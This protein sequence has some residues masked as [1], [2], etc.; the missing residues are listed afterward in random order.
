MEC[1][2][3]EVHV[4]GLEYMIVYVNK[5]SIGYVHHTKCFLP[6]CLQR[7]TRN[8]AIRRA[9]PCVW[10]GERHMPEALSLCHFPLWSSLPLRQVP[11]VPR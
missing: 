3:A 9:E 2:F 8:E 1:L 6:C 11:W 5:L 7:G 4:L 10:Y